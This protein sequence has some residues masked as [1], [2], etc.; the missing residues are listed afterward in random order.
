[1]PFRLRHTINA[2]YVVI[3]TNVN[4]RSSVRLGV[5]FLHAEIAQAAR[6]LAGRWRGYARVFNG[7]PG[8]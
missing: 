5:A 2:V 8:V 4:F 7:R 6:H 1:M 3:A